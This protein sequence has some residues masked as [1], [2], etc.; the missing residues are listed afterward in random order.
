VAAAAAEGEKIEDPVWLIPENSLHDDKWPWIL[1]CGRRPTAG[2]GH[3]P[4]II[5]A[6]VAPSWA[7]RI[8]RNSRRGDDA[9]RACV[10]ES[11]S[12]RAVTFVLVRNATPRDEDDDD[13]NNNNNQEGRP[14]DDRRMKSHN[15][16]RAAGKP[17]KSSWVL[18]AFGEFCQ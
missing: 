6:D 17:L 7:G 11:C 5:T 12:A 15:Y 1:I 3:P 8:R 14:R 9:P 2:G 10:I 16:R 13:I 4:I 18:R